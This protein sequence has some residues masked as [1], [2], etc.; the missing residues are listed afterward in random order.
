MGRITERAPTPEARRTPSRAQQYSTSRAAARCS[1][2]PVGL[3][4]MVSASPHRSFRFSCAAARRSAR[5]GGGACSSVTQRHCPSSGSA[6]SGSAN[7]GSPSSGSPS[8]GS[9]NCGGVRS[10][11]VRRR[12]T[13]HRPRGG[14]VR[15]RGRHHPGIE[16][17]E[18]RNGAPRCC[19]RRRTPA[20]ARS[21]ALGP[22]VAVAGWRHPAGDSDRAR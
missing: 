10:G 11:A 14:F 7:S 20:A 9:P 8:S 15:G 22:A 5:L 17:S 1:A 16:G 3:A 4:V 12:A 21:T 19:G 6:N 2:S 18:R 13:R